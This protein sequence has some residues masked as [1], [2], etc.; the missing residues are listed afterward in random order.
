[1]GLEKGLDLTDPLVSS[2]VATF[3][4]LPPNATITALSPSVSAAL[5][6]AIS[7]QSDA[8]ENAGLDPLLGEFHFD[9]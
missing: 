3:L 4:N 5:A 1:M 6:S 7:T 2:A 8:A 9:C